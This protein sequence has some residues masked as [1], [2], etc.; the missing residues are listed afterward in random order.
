M[1]WGCCSVLCLI[2][3]VQKGAMEEFN[4]LVELFFFSSQ[5]SLSLT[6]DVFMS[7]SYKKL[8]SSYSDEYFKYSAFLSHVS[9]SQM[10]CTMA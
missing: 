6:Q 1:W 8:L 7:S 5:L 9:N 2:T 4:N 3:H 10:D